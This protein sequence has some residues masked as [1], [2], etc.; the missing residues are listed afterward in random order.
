[1]T[2]ITNCLDSSINFVSKLLYCDV[3][4]RDSNISEASCGTLAVVDGI[5]ADKK[6]SEELKATIDAEKVANTTPLTNEGRIDVLIEPAPMRKLWLGY[7]GKSRILCGSTESITIMI[8]LFAGF[9][10]A[11]VMRFWITENSSSHNVLVETYV[12]MLFALWM[13]LLI[14]KVWTYAYDVSGDS[15]M[16]CYNTAVTEL[17]KKSIA[18]KL[19]GEGNGYSLLTELTPTN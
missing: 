4:L 19:M 11:C 5:S 10:C 18:M 8:V 17:A 13:G 1:M 3:V 9:F 12:P 7:T 14:C 15:I 6:K 16:F 2:P